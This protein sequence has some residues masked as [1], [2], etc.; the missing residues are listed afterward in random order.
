LSRPQLVNVADALLTNSQLH[1]MRSGVTPSSGLLYWYAPSA[2]N[3]AARH[4]TSAAPAARQH[5]PRG[6]THGT[7]AVPHTAS[8]GPSE[9]SGAGD[10]D[11]Q[12]TCALLHC[13]AHPR[14]PGEL[15]D[16]DVGDGT[17]G[18]TDDEDEDEDG[19]GDEVRAA[20]HEL[21][22]VPLREP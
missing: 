14:V 2:T 15:T 3:A 19:D 12:H 4:R 22:A 17:E 7:E 6:C 8:P 18:K 20:P 11:T 21:A 5:R 16:S 10:S 13:H 9:G 1:P